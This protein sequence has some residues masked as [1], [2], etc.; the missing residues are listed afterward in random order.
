[1][2]SIIDNK[3]QI[4]KKKLLDLSNRNRLLNYKETK[5]STLQIVYPEY[6]ELYKKLVLDEKDI[7]FPRVELSSILSEDEGGSKK[8]VKEIPGDIKTTKSVSDTHRIAKNLRSRAKTV[9][10]EQGVNILY[11]SFGFLEWQEKASSSLVF[12][13]PIVLVP[14]SLSIKSITDPYV[15]S[16]HEDE[17]VVN[18]TLQY[19]LEN[20]YKIILPEFDS[21]DSIADYL[22]KVERVVKKMGWK[23]NTEVSLSLLSFLRINMYKDLENRADA[24]ADNPIVKAIAGYKT[25]SDYDFAG[26]ADYDHDS[27][28]SV[29]DAFQVVDADSSQQDA[30]TMSKKG[31]SFVLQGPPGTGKS[32]TLTNIIAEGLAD[33]KKILFVSEKMAALDVVYKR[34]KQSEIADFCLVLHSNKANKKELLDSFREVLK[35]KEIKLNDDALFKLKDLDKQ[36]E[37]LNKYC[38]QLHKKIMPMNQ[39]VFE[40]NGIIA[41][42]ADVPDVDFSLTEINVS[43][44]DK[45]KEYKIRNAINEYTRT[46]SNLSID[47]DHNPWKDTK[48]NEV[49]HIER[50]SIVSLLVTI[51]NSFEFFFDKSDSAGE[52]LGIDFN[53]K[54]EDLPVLA[55]VFGHCKAFKAFPVQFLVAFDYEKL[56]SGIK[57]GKDRQNNIYLNRK[58]VEEFFKSDVFDADAIELCDKTDTLIEDAKGAIRSELSDS[59]MLDHLYPELSSRISGF[60]EFL[61][62]LEYVR[63]GLEIETIGTVSEFKAF[64]SFLGALDY[65]FRADREWFGPK[66]RNKYDR[67]RL[68]DNAEELSENIIKRRE[69]LLSEYDDDIL[70]LDYKPL[71]TRCRTDYTSFT[72][73]FRPT[74]KK[75]CDQIRALKK[76]PVKKIAYEELAAVVEQLKEY[77]DVEAE[78]DACVQ[79]NPELFGGWYDGWN[80]DY[81]KVRASWNQFDVMLSCLER[82]PDKVIGLIADGRNVGIYKN[83]YNRLCSYDDNGSLDEFCAF[84]KE[85]KV[86]NDF[87]KM[88]SQCKWI[89]SNL[90]QVFAELDKVSESSNEPI[91][92][93]K[94]YDVMHY[95]KSYQIL[96]NEEKALSTDLKDSYF[97]LYD[98]VDTDWDKA[99]ETVKWVKTFIE[100]RDAYSLSSGYCYGVATNSDYIDKSVEM[101]DYLKAFYQKTCNDIKRLDDLFKF[102]ITGMT[103]REIAD[104]ARSCNDDIQDLEAWID[105]SKSLDSCTVL[106]LSSFFK[107]TKKRDIPL[108]QYESVFIKTFEK[109]WIDFAE[110]SLPE[111]KAFRGR[112]QNKRIEEFKKLDVEQLRIN[113]IRI[114]EK[115]IRNIPNNMSFTSGD[116]E[117]SIL[118]RELNKQRRIMPVRKLFDSIPTLLPRLK[119][120]LMM[121]PLSVSQFLQSGQY[122]FDMVIFDEASQVRTENAIGAISRGKQVIIAGDIHQMPPTSFFTTT[123]SG[124]EDYDDEEEDDTLSYESVLDESN[125]VLPQLTLRWH[126]RSRNEALIAFSNREIYN[127][128]LVTFPSP[129]YESLED[130]VEYVY[131]KDGIYNRSTKRN[132]PVEAKIVVDKIFECISNNPDRS[133]GVITFSEAQQRCVEEEVLRRRLQNRD[134]EQYFAEDR[135]EPFFIKN[136]ENVQGDERDTI[137]FSIG[138]GK[139]SPDDEVRMNFGPLNREGGYRRLNVA[140]TRAKYSIKLVGS[141][142]PTDLRVTDATPKGVTLLKSYMDYAMNGQSVT[143]GRLSEREDY[144][145]AP[146]EDSVYRYL[147]GEGYAVDSNVGCSGYRIDLAIRHPSKKG[148]YALAVECDGSAYR[149]SRTAR[150]RDRLRQSVLESMGWH[151]YRIWSTDWVKDP[152][153]E[154]E[155]LVKAIKSAIRAKD[156]PDSS[157]VDDVSESESYFVEKKTTSKKDSGFGVYS[158]WHFRKPDKASTPLRIISNIKTIAEKQAPIHVYYVAKQVAP[159]YLRENATE[160][161]KTDIKSLIAD[162]GADYDLIRRG[163]YVWMRTPKLVVPKKPKNDDNLRKIELIA[164]EELGQAMQIIVANSF[165][166]DKTGLFKNVTLEYGY[167]RST[168]AMEPYLDDALNMLLRMGRVIDNNGKLSVALNIM[169]LI[170][171]SKGIEGLTFA[172]NGKLYHYKKSE[173]LKKAIEDHGGIYTDSINKNT[174]Y[175][176]SNDN[177]TLTSKIKDASSKGIPII[178]EA[179]FMKIIDLI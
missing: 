95:L 15:M 148:V 114:R 120:C 141:F 1:M 85:D 117:L 56:S 25:N 133:I 38:L 60:E 93:S 170:E 57:A 150:D 16:L 138:Y 34:L 30:I 111:V 42:L 134:Y 55:D 73:V 130:G 41:E 177:I 102:S 139:S 71:L 17:V 74:Y 62:L 72:R 70:K 89:K 164:P 65:D 153:S 154:G 112:N 169:N 103:M 86:Q 156:N 82:V 100:Y 101:S 11:L 79:K 157:S 43:K 96:I 140:I 118:N 107:E 18:P 178:T 84:L 105:Y 166:L 179:E 22:K 59:Y 10:E 125:A 75:D 6:A 19:K 108:N 23:V 146:F 123:I 14:V 142:L 29:V 53:Y 162:Y 5:Q 58:S 12:K 174:D 64:R 49:G 39:S 149:S 155:R 3:L 161:I 109:H 21:Q 40:A 46:V 67:N 26:M 37:T 128:D 68:I 163:E 9:Q 106:G 176:I 54:Y 144:T 51:I 78:F 2:A 127:S 80:T 116:D 158:E 113:R 131:V 4:W 136:L 44:T 76:T 160:K 47:V 97:E 36:R 115:L 28:E 69:K 110:N 48:L 124:N 88:L 94:I 32:Q 52:Y 132:N 168:S 90:E 143:D 119:P 126:Y 66:W 159:L 104:K 35:L 61:T 152:A 24:I 7:V 151:F 122:I 147:V 77:H 45:D 135:D 50:N 8:Q 31:A 92:Y 99:E 121:S 98:G 172:V 175:L 63:N 87:N 83:E 13:S 27:T 137:I 145:E 20:D 129:H 91:P 171:E 173:V 165:G 33:G 81:S 167:S